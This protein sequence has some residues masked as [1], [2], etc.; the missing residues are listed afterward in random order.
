MDKA[1]V[2][3]RP[4]IQDAKI[5]AIQMSIQSMCI[6]ASFASSC[7]QAFENA[8]NKEAP[9][10]KDASKRTIRSFLWLPAWL[11]AAGVCKFIQWQSFCMQAT[12]SE[13][14][15]HTIHS[16]QASV[17]RCLRMGQFHASVFSAWVAC[18]HDR[19]HTKNLVGAVEATWRR[20][21]V[22]EVIMHWAY[23]AKVLSRAKDMQRVHMHGLVEKVCAIPYDFIFGIWP[24][25]LLFWIYA[26]IYDV[27]MLTLAWAYINDDT[28]AYINST[29]P[30]RMVHAPRAPIS[31]HPRHQ[32]ESDRQTK[33]EHP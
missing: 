3:G 22:E 19:L 27:R 10:Y 24:D 6:E 4:L 33:A 7:V 9:N 32:S 23:I 11:A 31:D 30:Q 13:W 5:S 16:R 26:G 18:H 1:C 17:A 25:V 14:R 2:E 8:F 20:A 12:V 28:H 15:T 29:G 21:R